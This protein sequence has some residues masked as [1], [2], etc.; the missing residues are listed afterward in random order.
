MIEVNVHS[1]IGKLNG[2]LLHTPGEEV[3]NMTPETA[4]RAL[5]SDILNLAIAREE[6]KQL[7]DV[8]GKVT[9][10]YQVKE[11]LA[12]LLKEETVKR[13]VLDRIE[14]IEPF[15]AEEGPKGSLKEW[16]MNESAANLARLLIEG[17]EMKR[18]TLTKFLNKDWY[19]LRPLHNCF[20]TRDAAMSLYNEVLIGKMANA[21]RDR[22]A[23]IMQSIFDF[24]PGLRAKTLLLPTGDPARV[25]TIEGG[26]LLVAR[27]DILLI[28]TGT[29]TNARAI[30]LLMYEFIRRKED[31]VQHIIVQE[32]P[33][34]PESFIHLD[35]VFTFLDRDKCM[36]YEPLVLNPG[37]YQTVH[38]KIHNGRLLGIR[39][40]KSIIHALR[41][42]GMDLEPVFC[43]G[44]DEW[45]QEREQWHSG[46]N[47]FCVAPGKVIGYARNN[48]TVEALARAGFEIIRARDVIR[49]K[50]DLAHHERY[51]ITIEGS[52]LP[53]GGGGARCMTMPI[54]RD[55]VEW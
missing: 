49:D 31:K 3:E 28:G 51:M 32:L 17:V 7:A 36:V 30:D 25:P 29:R 46:A 33:H 21:V 39:R 14:K 15:I 42:L 44:D 50:V 37:P 16:L 43:G 40:E 41:K 4:P 52:E 34:A 10:V 35:M 54:H 19:D 48:Y 55:P 22:E 5:Y 9:R 23:V 6:H 13:E 18:D 47:F 20:F 8:L 24:T 26:D 27:E 1:E 12:D 38:V 2:V 11:L 45:N 53:R